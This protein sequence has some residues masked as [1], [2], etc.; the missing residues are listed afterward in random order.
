MYS[1]VE[2]RCVDDAGAASSILAVTAIFL[3]RCLLTSRRQPARQADG[4]FY[5]ILLQAITRR[6]DVTL[7]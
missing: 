6:D 7:K 4:N 5:I 2:E 1:S 3:R